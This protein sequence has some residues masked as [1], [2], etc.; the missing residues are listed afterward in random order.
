MNPLRVI[1]SWEL[2][3]LPPP[4]IY[5]LRSGERNFAVVEDNSSI[6]IAISKGRVVFAISKNKALIEE[7]DDTGFPRYLVTN[8]SNLRVISCTEDTITEPKQFFV[9]KNITP[10]L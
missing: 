9:L 7:I 1:K 8:P 6:I 4:S 10:L 3:S 2:S 5:F